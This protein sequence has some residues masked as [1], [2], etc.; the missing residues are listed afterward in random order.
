MPVQAQVTTALYQRWLRTV[1]QLEVRLENLAPPAGVEPATLG[2][3]VLR[4]VQLSYG[5]VSF[6]FAHGMPHTGVHRPS[7]RPKPL[8]WLW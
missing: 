8:R 2:L 5:G 1:D 4:S 6:S 3:E 7:N